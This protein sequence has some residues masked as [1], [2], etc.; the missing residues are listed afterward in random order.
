MKTLISAAIT[1]ALLGGQTATF[2]RAEPR[3]SNLI[4]YVSGDFNF[5][6]RPD[7]VGIVNNGGFAIFLGAANGDFEDGRLFSV[8]SDVGFPGVAADFNR[9]GH[10]DLAAYFSSDFDTTNGWIEGVQ[11]YLGDGK[12][13]FAP[14]ARATM[15]GNWHEGLFSAMADVNRD[16]KPDLVVHLFYWDPVESWHV[17]LGRGDGSFQLL[18]QFHQGRASNM[19]EPVLADLNADGIPDLVTQGDSTAIWLGAG[20]GTFRK[21]PP[22]DAL[23][24]GL[25]ATADFDRDGRLDLA[26]TNGELEAVILFGNGDGSF[27]KGS[28][29]RSR[30]RNTGQ[31]RSVWAADLNARRGLSRRAHS[32][33]WSLGPG[34]GRVERA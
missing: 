24:G 9:D 17:L 30:S 27:R 21:G 34:S 19:G 3:P 18:P 8:E 5:D 15:P 12:G 16:G 31:P 22:A 32:F 23:P 33:A 4:G 11:V 6:G 13:G 25:V 20:D 2:E 29:I 7:L 26:K 14:G 10:L 1:A 28:P